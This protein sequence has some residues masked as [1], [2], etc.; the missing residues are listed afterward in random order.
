MSIL[1]FIKANKPAASAPG[2]APATRRTDLVDY[3]THR[4]LLLHKVADEPIELAAGVTVKPL[5]GVR[6]LDPPRQVVLPRSTIQNGLNQGYVSVVEPG[7]VYIHTGPSEDPTRNVEALETYKYVVFHTMDGD[8]TY[9]ITQQP[10]R[11]DRAYYG[12]AI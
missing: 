3:G 5:K 6:L 12:R 10:C 8:V 2:T 7:I 4:G 11:E 1:D 9:E